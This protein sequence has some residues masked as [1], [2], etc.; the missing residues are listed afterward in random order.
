M[1]IQTV[2]RTSRL[3]AV[4]LLGALAVALLPGSLRGEDIALAEPHATNV[5]W[6]MDGQDMVISYDLI[7]DSLAV[8]TVSVSLLRTGD[9]EFRVVPVRAYG[10][11]GE[12]KFAGLGRSIR[13]RIQE[14]L[15]ELPEG[16]DFV[17]EVSV[18][19]PDTLPWFL[20]VVGVAVGG[21]TIYSF[22][23]N[24]E[25]GEPPPILEL[26]GPPARP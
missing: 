23:Q 19:E 15:G 18:E 12:G 24:G 3:P 13:W 8:Y 21:A 22:V 20:V 26:P 9:P 25:E 16:D 6:V 17:V 2:R 11:L 5:D 7:G 4:L 10:A 1:I 14:E